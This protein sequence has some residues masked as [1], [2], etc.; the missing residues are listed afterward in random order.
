MPPKT[1][2]DNVKE[3]I[4]GVEIA[5]PYRWL[6]DR[7]SP[8]TAEW[9]NAQN[10]Y[11]DTRIGS[12]PG[13][14][15]LKQRLTELMRTDLVGMPLVRNCRYFF[16]KRK[17][18][19][20]LPVIYMRKGFGGKDE[21]LIDPH[22][23]SA[24]RTTS[25]SISDVSE[26]GSVMAYAV[27]KGGQDETT[28]SLLDVDKGKDLPDRLPKGRYWGISLKPD[29][30]GFYYARY[31]DDGS[32]VCY[33]RLGT[34]PSTDTE[35]FGKGYGPDKMIAVDLSEDGR[36]LLITVFH[37]SAAKKTEVYYQELAGNG[38]IVPIVNDI[39]AR[40]IGEIAGDHLFLQTDWDAPKGRIF[41]VDLHNP[42]RE[43]WQEV[44]RESDAVIEGFSL[45]G[46][47]LFVNYLHNVSS[48]VRVFEP[49]GKPLRD[50]AFPAI[51]SVSGIGGRWKSNE[52]FFSFSS[53]HIPSTIYRYDVATGSRDV[54]WRLKVPINSERFEVKQV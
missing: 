24:D 3:T 35:L 22:P 33:H 28:V 2:T 29:K 41:R 52:A 15:K 14:E 49:D 38:P 39:D 25:V 30:S 50:I 19:Q 9:I 32:R 10:E 53:F 8:E 54:W 31:R 5:D 34:D 21:V 37:G 4:H 40:F 36:Y 46:G 43:A 11:T 7:G 42:A 23:M 44:I 20:E 45:V 51:G 26:D 18:D 1:R 12:L 27:R 13:R 6:E 48:R 47:K 17:R 16:S